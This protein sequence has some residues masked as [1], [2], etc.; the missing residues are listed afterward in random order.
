ME[1][2]LK[3]FSITNLEKAIVGLLFVF[4]VKDPLCGFFHACKLKWHKRFNETVKANIYG[5]EGIIESIGI[6]DTTVDTEDGWL[7]DID[8]S[9]VHFS[10]R[11]TYDKRRDKIG[12]LE[13]RIAELEEKLAKKE[14]KKK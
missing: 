13:A 3:Q 8:T 14:R 4:I 2:L 9:R 5:K 7:W 11:G 6:F 1:E 12:A 10:P